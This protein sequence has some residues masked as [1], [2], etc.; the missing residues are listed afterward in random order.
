VK[1]SALK[2]DDFSL[3]TDIWICSIYI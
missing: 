1:T 2:I 3:V